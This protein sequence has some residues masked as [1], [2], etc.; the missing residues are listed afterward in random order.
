MKK[1]S[2]P[3]ADKLWRDAIRKAA[4][5][6]AEGKRGPKKLELAARALV[7]AA[8]VGDVSA[9]KEMGDRLDGKV[10]QAVTGEGGGPVAMAITWLSPSA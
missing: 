5:E 7:D 2:G 1:P 10:P 6:Q 4:L 9:A 3:F 8:I